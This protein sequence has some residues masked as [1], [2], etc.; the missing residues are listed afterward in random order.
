VSEV[1]LTLDRREPHR[2]VE[3]WT[4]DGYRLFR[5]VCE[6]G[7]DVARFD[8]EDGRYADLPRAE[9][10]LALRQSADFVEGKPCQS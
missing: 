5:I 10:A 9:L 6:P 8:G 2:R 7:G 3:L 4:A 1:E